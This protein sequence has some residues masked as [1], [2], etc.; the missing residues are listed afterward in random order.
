M[1]RTAKRLNFVPIKVHGLVFEALLD[2]GAVS[3]LISPA[4]SKWLSLKRLPTPK[5]ITTAEVVSMNVS[6]AG[7]EFCVKFGSIPVLIDHLVVYGTIFS[8]IIVCPA[9]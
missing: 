1:S 2:S 3:N 7:K 8:V 9:L 6:G 5:R 4:L